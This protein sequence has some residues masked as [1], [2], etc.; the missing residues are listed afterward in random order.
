MDMPTPITCCAPRVALHYQGVV[1]GSLTQAMLEALQE[2]QGADFQLSTDGEGPRAEVLTGAL[3]ETL[4]RLHVRLADTQLAPPAASE[5]VDIWHPVTQDRLGRVDRKLARL[6]G[7]EMHSAH[8]LL[9]S[10]QGVCLQRRALDKAVDPGLWDT[11]VGGTRMAGESIDQT[12]AREMFEEAGLRPQQLDGL[13]WLGMWTFDQESRYGPYAAWQHEKMWVWVARA[14]DPLWEPN[15][16]DGEVMEFAWRSFT[17][18]AKSEAPF[19][20][21]QELRVLLGSAQWHGYLAGNTSP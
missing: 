4:E 7:M 15:C 18:L 3:G 11:T 10:E 16:G 8:L 9:V 20:Y 14:A 19:A 13:G 12:L 5:Q 17:D 6:L 2:F 1:L 21:T